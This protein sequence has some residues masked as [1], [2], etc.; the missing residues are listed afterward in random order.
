M[1]RVPTLSIV[2]GI[3]L[4]PNHDSE[5]QLTTF[6]SHNYCTCAPPLSTPKIS[7]SVVS[8]GGITVGILEVVARY[9]TF[10]F[11]IIVYL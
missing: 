10:S 6:I 8:R 7:R 9:T 1:Y 3:Q 4:F 2:S 5:L 11:H